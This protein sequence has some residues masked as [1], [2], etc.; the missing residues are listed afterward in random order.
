[1]KQYHLTLTGTVGYSNFDPD[2]VD[3]I[4]SQH[5]DEEVCVRIAS[6]GGYAG[7][8]LRIMD[9]FRNHGNVS[10]H[11]VS[12]NASAATIVALGAKKVTIDPAGF[13][14]VHNSLNTIDV[15]SLMNAAEIDKFIKDLKKTAAHL[16]DLD[17][18]IASVYVNKTGKDEKE[19]LKLM[20]KDDWITAEEALEWGFVDAIESDGEPAPITQAQAEAL[21]MAMDLPKIPA[22]RTGSVDRIIDT[23]KNELSKFFKKFNMDKEPKTPETTSEEVTTP[24]PV[25]EAVTTPEAAAV[26]TPSLEQRVA[27]LEQRLSSPAAD[28]GDT[29][30]TPENNGAAEGAKPRKQ[31]I[32]SKPA[33]NAKG[34]DTFAASKELFDKLP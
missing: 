20:A 16:E 22:V 27:A 4:L 17:K 34:L 21:C 11:L 32:S 8:A 26:E 29:S 23:V 6:L 25:P 5:Q 13:F 1:M 33:T 3:Y 30:A 9:S 15:F 7:S 19:I 12:Y 18:V 10:V 2:Y 28:A 14:C 24:A 31:V